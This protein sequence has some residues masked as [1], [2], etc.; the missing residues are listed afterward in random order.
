MTLNCQTF[1][2][3]STQTGWSGQN[4]QSNTAYTSGTQAT[5]TPQTPLSAST[6]YF[7][8]SY[9]IDPGGINTW[10]STQGTPNSFTT[11]TTAPTAPTDP[12]AE[13]TTNPPGVL[14][15]TP[16]FSAVHNDPD[17][18]TANYYEIEVNTAS[19]FGGTVMWDT[20]AV[21]MASL[22]SGARSS[23][24][25]YAGTT[26]TFSGS[27]YYWRI[28]FTDVNGAVGSWSAT[29]NFTMNTA[30]ST[31][32][33]D[34]PTNGATNQSLTPALRTTTTDTNGDYLRYKIELC[35]NVGMTL[36][37]QTF[38]QTSTQTGWSGQNTQ[39]NTAYTSGTQA[40]YTPQTPLSASTTYFWRS[41]SIDPG[42]I[43]TWSSTQGTPNSFTT[44]ISNTL[45]IEGMNF[46][47]MSIN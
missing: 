38:D 37:C 13:G 8:R 6:T 28:R 46:E 3:T 23:D 35:T 30:P 33:L 14:D 10:S 27:T 44:G 31:P 15:T 36:N 34:S 21:S 45:Y 20:G 22:A 18:D 32:T 17:S 42:G 25:S 40:T 2:Q 19:N 39:S 12:L 26:L 29:Q 9:S 16:E 5:Y 4:T 24:V 7:W 41:Y 47:G 1:D 43:N 11:T